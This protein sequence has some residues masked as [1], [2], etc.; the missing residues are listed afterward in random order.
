MLS[1]AA[2]LLVAILLG[3]C[4]TAF[5]GDNTAALSRNASE[6]DAA[7]EEAA[8]TASAGVAAPTDMAAAAITE[9]ATFALG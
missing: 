8:V 3:A 9:T 7:S 4:A 6:R 5:G 1:V 2:L